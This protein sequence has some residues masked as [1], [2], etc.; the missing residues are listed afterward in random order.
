MKNHK[1]LIL[2]DPFGCLGQ[3]PEE[4]IEEI[5]A[6]VKEYL[7][8]GHKLKSYRVHC[9]DPEAVVP[10]TDLVLFDFGGMLA[11]NDLAG[12]NARALLKWAENN[13][14]A[15]VLVTSRFTFQHCVAFEM[16][17][18]GLTLP[19][20]INEHEARTEENKYNPL[21]AWWLK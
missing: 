8:K 14:A 13:P 20:V 4:E 1:T 15:L 2:V 17:E 9:F 18:L 12:S 11:G 3:S 10:G 5:L 16:E 6:R 21:P 7:P 19:N